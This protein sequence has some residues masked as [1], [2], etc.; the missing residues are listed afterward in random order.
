M[1]FVGIS[2]VFLTVWGAFFIVFIW[3]F[4]IFYYIKTNNF[5]PDDAAE[6]PVENNPVFVW[7]Y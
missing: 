3:S 6:P 7:P 1:L 4:H 2:P 5:I